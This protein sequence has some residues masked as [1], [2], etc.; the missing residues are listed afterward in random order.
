MKVFSFGLDWDSLT[1]MNEINNVLIDL[2]YTDHKEKPLKKTVTFGM[3]DNGESAFLI[4]AYKKE[5]ALRI[6]AQNQKSILKISTGIFNKI[7]NEVEDNIKTEVFNTKTDLK[8]A[9]D[10]LE[11]VVYDK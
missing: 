6:V 11:K 3:N 1:V 8:K 4:Y 10:Y 2:G 9:S 7:K 5:K